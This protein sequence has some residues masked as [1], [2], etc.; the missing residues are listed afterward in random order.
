MKKK[1]TKLQEIDSI[2]A[3]EKA[4]GKKI[5]HCHGCFDLLH[6]GHIKH[7]EAAKQFGDVLVVTVTEDKHVNKGPDRPYFDHN[8]RIHN[9][10]A[11]EVVD[12]VAVNYAP[13]AIPAIEAI[14]PDY[15][16]KGQDY[17]D[18][19]QDISGGIL[20]EKEAAEEYGGQLVFRHGILGF[21]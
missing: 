5:V 13:T 17:K 21:K 11:L 14:K 12:Y 3:E 2:L 16:V 19:N 8:V 6:H 9:L 1:V 18:S 7:F 4:A 15:Y 20:K 10:A